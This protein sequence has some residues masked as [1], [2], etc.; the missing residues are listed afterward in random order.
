MSDYGNQPPGGQGGQ[1][2]GQGG[3][4]GQGGQY[5]QGDAGQYGGGQYGGGQ[6]GGGQ[7]GG[8]QYGGEPPRHPS[9][10]TVLVLGIL[11]LVVCG[12][13]APFAWIKGNGVLREIDAAPGRYSG[14]DQVSIGRILGIIGTALLAFGLVVFVLF[15]IIAVAGV[16]TSP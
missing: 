6:Y 13:L 7:Y 10:T 4:G 5:G 14:R 3:P 16:S 8:G 11:G 12:V 9:A 2:G 1:Y 15:L